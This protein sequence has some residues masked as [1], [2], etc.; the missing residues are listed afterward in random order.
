MERL[1]ELFEAR[2]GTVP[3]SIT[4]IAGSASDRSYSRMQDADGN[5][6]IGVVGTDV[7]ENEAFASLTQDEQQMLLK[8][9]YYFPGGN[10]KQERSVAALPQ[11]GVQNRPK[12]RGSDCR[13]LRDGNGK[14]IKTNTFPAN[15]CVLGR[16]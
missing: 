6:C 11:R 7:S 16:A 2:Y 4:P 3:V 15:R 1:H 5:S 10:Q 12:G 8:K 14:N 13:T 9:L